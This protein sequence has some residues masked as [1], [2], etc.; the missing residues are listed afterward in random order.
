MLFLILG[1]L[2]AISDGF[3][4]ADQ[5]YSLSTKSILDAS[6][7]MSEIKPSLALNI[8][9]QFV[10][11]LGSGGP[12]GSLG[13]LGAYGPLGT[14]G[15]LGN[16]LWNVS[17]IMTTMGDWSELA[18]YYT[19]N[20]G[21]LSS[22]GPLGSKGPLSPEA[23]RL[24]NK[25]PGLIAHLGAG[26]MFSVLG[27][28][29]PLGAVGP[30][31]PLGPL[32]AHGFKVNQDGEYVQG[33]NVQRV[34]SV[35]YDGTQKRQ[36]ELFEHYPEQTAKKMVDNDASFMVS[37]RL[38]QS[39]GRYEVDSYSFTARENQ[40]VTVVVAPEYSLDQFSVK[41]TSADG[42]QSVVSDMPYHINFVQFLARQGMRYQLEVS[43]LRSNH[44]FSKNYRAIV[45]SVNADIVKTQFQ[46]PYLQRDQ[47]IDCQY[48]L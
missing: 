24:M 46:G 43:L 12:L 36:Y 11:L 7:K 28:F 20:G 23:I 44:L 6:E 8:Q 17:E 16:Q 14:L 1:C 10:M 30:L 32:G 31:G 26:G 3:A 45:T 9:A 4:K 22:S 5:D 29:G 42:R 13:P 48:A 19:L 15:P 40:L 34:V 21:P 33:Q 41:I 37:G 35:D 18:K 27:P 39:K 38:D 47:K 25:T 2:V